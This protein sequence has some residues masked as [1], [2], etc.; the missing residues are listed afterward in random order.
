MIT[1]ENYY[2][3]NNKGLSQSKIKMYDK[4][5]NYMYRACISGELVRPDNKSF[6]IGRETD[7]ILTEMDKFQNTIIAPYADF[8]SKEAREWR[9]EQEAEGKTVVKETEYENIMAIA[10]AVQE[11]EVW[12]DIEKTFTT[13][14]ILQVVDKKLGRHFDCLYGKPDAFRINEDGVCDLC[15][16]KTALK[17]D[18]KTFFYKSKDYGYFKQLW[19]YAMLLKEKYP[20]IKSFRYWFVVAEKSEPYRVS[21]FSIPNDLVD[22][23]EMDM[24]LTIKEI[25][26]RTDYSRPR[27]GWDNAIKLTDPRQPDDGWEDVE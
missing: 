17:I 13:Q 26:Q 9:K 11:T 15:D 10:I 4:D 12:Q 21:L 18:E 1:N 27:I 7:S 6:M 22:D 23:C 25:S 8:R 3:L 16:L 14:E 5:P 20:Q 2:S 24:L 19:M